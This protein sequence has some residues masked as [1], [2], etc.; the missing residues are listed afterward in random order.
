MTSASVRQYMEQDR[1]STKPQL[2]DDSPWLLVSSMHHTLSQPHP[3]PCAPETV[4]HDKI[5]VKPLW[6]L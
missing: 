3:L 6:R 4:H 2:P 1:L 5:A